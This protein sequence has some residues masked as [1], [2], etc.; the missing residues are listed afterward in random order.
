M[1]KYILLFML[2]LLSV[3]CKGQENETKKVEKGGNKTNVIEEPKGTW[4]VD[5]EFD[6]NGNLT[7]YDSIY[8]WSSNKKL[9]NLS[10]SD[11]D[12][13]I[14]SFKSR[15]FSNFSGF[16]NQGFDN[17][18]SKDSLFS[19]HFFNDHFFESEFGNDFMNIDTLRQQMIVRQKKFL[20]KYQS[21][22]IK[23]KDEN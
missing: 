2:G 9:E 22:F 21:E 18:F 6:E 23:P 7:K 20:E 19:K 8:S 13:L 15:F 5:K 1:K 14:E 11:R 16:E 3:G 17:V 12:S 10:L 4:K